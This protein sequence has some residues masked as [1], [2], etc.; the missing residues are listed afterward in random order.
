MTSFV[1]TFPGV[2]SS[3]GSVQAQALG[4]GSD[5]RATVAGLL[6]GDWGPWG[7]GLELPMTFLMEKNMKKPSS[8]PKKL[9][10]TTWYWEFEKDLDQ[11]GSKYVLCRKNLWKH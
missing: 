8:I 7:W 6:Q 9:E 3:A 1:G 10:K 4:L 2:G 5:L 11:L